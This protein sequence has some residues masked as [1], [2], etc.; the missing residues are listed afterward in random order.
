MIYNFINLEKGCCYE[1]YV[2]LGFKEFKNLSG[3]RVRT[4]NHIRFHPIP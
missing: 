1:E 2:D 3:G 4:R